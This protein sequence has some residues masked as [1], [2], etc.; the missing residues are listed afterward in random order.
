MSIFSFFRK[1]VFRDLPAKGEKWLLTSGDPWGSKY[2]PV[3]ILD[4][5]EGW[6]RYKMGTSL[7]FNDERMELETFMD[8]YKRVS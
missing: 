6:V 4:Q 1:K 7:A 8:I 3:T 5:K 2:P